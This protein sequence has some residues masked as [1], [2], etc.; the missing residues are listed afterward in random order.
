MIGFFKIPLQR[1]NFFSTYANKMRKIARNER[2][3][4]HTLYTVHRTLYTVH[5]TLYTVHFTP[6]TYI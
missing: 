3:F 1:Y 6:Y 4:L 2:F 5:R